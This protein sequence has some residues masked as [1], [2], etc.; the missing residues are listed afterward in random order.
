MNHVMILLFR[1]VLE[2][3]LQPAWKLLEGKVGI[4]IFEFI[5]EKLKLITPYL[6]RLG[7]I[8][9]LLGY[10]NPI[11]TMQWDW[12]PRLHYDCMLLWYRFMQWN[13]EDF[14]SNCN[15]SYIICNTVCPNLYI[16]MTLLTFHVDQLRIC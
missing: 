1:N 7:Y 3:F 2:Q 8:K 12:D 9:R 13:S 4:Y 6:L 11:N 15:F 16:I 5:N 10:K 14:P